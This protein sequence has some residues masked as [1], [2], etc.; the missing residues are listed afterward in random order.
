MLIERAVPALGVVAPC[1]D[2]PWPEARLAYDNARL[3]EAR[4]AAGAVLGD[5]QLLTDGLHLLDWLVEVETR[6]DVFSFTGQWGWGPGDARPGFD[7]QPIE[8]GA[9]ADACARAYD[10]T[11][12]ERWVDVCLRAAEWFLGRNDTGVPWSTRRPEAAPTA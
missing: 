3:P 2:W 7:Q 10:V 11:G 12:D 9:M 1:L 5:A 6:G 4:I 8:A